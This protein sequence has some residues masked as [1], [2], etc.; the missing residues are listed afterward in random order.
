MTLSFLPARWLD[1]RN[2]A[3][4]KQAPSVAKRSAALAT[5]CA[6]IAGLSFGVAAPSA[7]AATGS[8]Q[9]ADQFLKLTGQPGPHRVK[10]HYF[11]SPGVPAAQK[12]IAPRTLV[13][14]STPIAVGDSV[15]TLAVAGVDSHGNK[16]GITAGHCGNPGAPVMSL[17]NPKGGKI[18]TVVRK[19][20]SD[21]GIIKFN[22]NVQLTRNY[23]RVA[24]NQLG[25]PL[26]VTGQQICKTGITTGTSC[27]PMIAMDGPMLVAHFCGSHGDSGA[28][29]Y[30]RGRLVGIVNGGLYNL[31]S[32][33]TPLQGP[34]HA[35]AAGAAWPVIK[36]N[37]EANGG[38]GAGFRLP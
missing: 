14:P 31:P 13:G 23:G 36:A 11:T 17:D 21:V 19:G 37:L 9:A 15:C 24:I 12:A 27:G 16:V 18:G 29:I 10:G 38:V 26:P 34:F 5:A 33:R 30:S 2:A 7:S 6:A 35:P 1:K 22:S 3:V 8:S 28:P 32:C 4:T 20:V 25:G